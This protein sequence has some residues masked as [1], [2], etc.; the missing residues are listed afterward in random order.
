MIEH[1]HDQGRPVHDLME[2]AGFVGVTAHRD[3]AG[4]DRVTTGRLGPR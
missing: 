3:L 4:R 2:A 1:G